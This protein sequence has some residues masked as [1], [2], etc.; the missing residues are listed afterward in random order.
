MIARYLSAGS[1]YMVSLPI[2]IFMEVCFLRFLGENLWFMN[3]FTCNEWYDFLLNGCTT[4]FSEHSHISE[5]SGNWKSLPYC[6]QPSSY[7]W[8]LSVRTRKFNGRNF[9]STKSIKQYITLN[10]ASFPIS[11]FTND[12]DSDWR[13]GSGMCSENPAGLSKEWSLYSERRYTG[14]CWQQPGPG[15]WRNRI[16]FS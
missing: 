13:L 3:P 4:F 7:P 14:S 16:I 1:D 11:K 8:N 9:F 12:S 5:Y 2:L 10:C 15:N 6:Q